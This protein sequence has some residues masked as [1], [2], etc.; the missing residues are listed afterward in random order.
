MKSKGII[1][2]TD[3][4]SEFIKQYSREY[5]S[6]PQKIQTPV[7]DIHDAYRI[8]IVTAM[9]GVG[10][11]A[12][13]LQT[14]VQLAQQ[15]IYT[16]LF[17]YEMSPLVILTRL[18]SNICKIPKHEIENHQIEVERLQKHIQEATP[19]LQYIGISESNCEKEIRESIETLY[20]NP[21][22]SNLKLALGWDYLQRMACHKSNNPRVDIEHTLNLISQ[23]TT[24]YQAISFII[25]SANRN[26]YDSY[27]IDSGRD[28][29]QIEFDADTLTMLRIVSFNQESATW[30]P[31]PNKSNEYA[32]EVAKSKVYIQAS[33]IKNRHGAG[34][35]K[36]FL[37]DKTIQ[38]FTLVTAQQDQNTDHRL[39]TGN[40]F[41]STSNSNIDNKKTK[42][43]IIA[44][45]IPRRGRKRNVNQ[46]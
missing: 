41:N 36:I 21:D 15:G 39:K 38:T 42:E 5:V 43:Q 18:I 1:M 12:Y 25:S 17:S 33:V 9:P 31:V 26:G 2:T 20:K 29:G 3:L 30:Q 16:V 45:I 22:I 37:F 24:D 23:I 19:I 10:K 14:A 13:I 46:F 6:P 34:A 28:S 44:E 7:I 35:Q 32:Q 27:G 40:I 4:V 8:N 11:S